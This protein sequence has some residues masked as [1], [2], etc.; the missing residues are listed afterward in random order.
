MKYLR[1]VMILVC[2]VLVGCNSEQPYTIVQFEDVE[3]SLAT[4]GELASS[5]TVEVGPPF[6]KHTWQYKIT[7]IAPEGTLVKKGDVIIRFD[8]QQQHEGLRT[9]SNKLATQQQKL[10][11]E[12]LNSEQS[13]EKLK[14]DIAETKM[15]LA[16]AQRK[17]TQDGDYSRALDIKKL[18]I[19]LAIA[20]K[21]MALINY[22]NENKR[23]QIKLEGE[24]NQAEV[25]RLSAE[26]TERQQ[27]ITDM[28]VKAPKDGIVVYVPGNEQKKPATGDT[29]F[30]AQKLI[31]LPNLSQMVVNTTIAENDVSRISLGQR[32]AIELDAIQDQRFWG[33]VTALGAVVRVK[34]A[35][36]PSKVYDAVIT[37]ETPDVEK[38]R[39]GM[40]AR[41]EIQEQLLN[42]VVSVPIKSLHFD[43][44]QAQVTINRTFG[45]SVVDVAV[46]GKSA[47]TAYIKGKL[48]NGEQILR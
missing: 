37:I 8:A 10:Q 4:T 32:V 5:D 20:T 39:P 48:S 43:Q 31:E 23:Q 16:K 33:K 36:D 18:K 24:I 27:A 17:S 13:V 14:L 29:V 3:L 35:K 6:I 46:L 12:V 47:G 25:E 34:S 30:M 41:L 9:S 11:S 40:A 44:L 22:R 38:M 42:Q 15:K 26:V 1:I 28:N 7:D 2:V 45:T 21:E 19:D